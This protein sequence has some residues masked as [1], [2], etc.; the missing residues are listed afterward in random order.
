MNPETAAEDFRGCKFVK[1]ILEPP[2]GM[3]VVETVMI[4]LVE[5]WDEVPKR[6]RNHKDIEALG[7]DALIGARI[8]YAGSTNESNR[9]NWAAVNLATGAGVQYKQSA[10]RYSGRLLRFNISPANV[11]EEEAARKEK[12]KRAAEQAA[13]TRKEG[14]CFVHGFGYYCNGYEGYD[15]TLKH[16]Q[17]MKAASPRRYRLWGEDGKWNLEEQ[18]GYVSEESDSD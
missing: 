6:I 10:S 17:E 3:E 1:A 8:R 15:T 14:K 18:M 11:A 5:G 16:A 9:F 13:L 12:R 7:C 4:P 2:G